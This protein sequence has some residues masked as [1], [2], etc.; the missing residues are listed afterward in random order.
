[1]S[2]INTLGTLGKPLQLNYFR[3]VKQRELR[4]GSIKKPFS[5]LSRNLSLLHQ[6]SVRFFAPIAMDLWRRSKLR[7]LHS[8]SRC[9]TVRG[10]N[11]ATN[12]SPAARILFG[13]TSSRSTPCDVLP[14]RFPKTFYQILAANPLPKLKPSALGLPST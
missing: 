12:I 5:A 7:T 6:N 2:H 1:L 14:L 4:K 8:H 10:A 11:I 3:N 9:L 13:P